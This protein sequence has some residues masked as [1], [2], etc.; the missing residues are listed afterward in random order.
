MKITPITNNNI[1][2]RGSVN[3]NINQLLY[4]Y[5]GTISRQVKLIEQ[6]PQK[7]TFLPAVL[8][9]IGLD[10]YTMA[11]NIKHNLEAIMSRFDKSCELVYHA[12]EKNPAKHLFAIK[13][14]N[15]DHV[16]LCGTVNLEGNSYRKDFGAIDKFINDNLAKINPYEANLKFKTMSRVWGNFA[17]EKEIWFIEDELV[18]MN[19]GVIN[20]SQFDGQKVTFGTLLDEMGKFE[21]QFGEKVVDIF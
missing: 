13:S 19:K 16:E 7:F 20:P 2:S 6:C 21:E 9:A 14:N 4:N 10:V 1:S 17:P 3:Y 15:S 8:S 18:D 12:S 5:P 11:D